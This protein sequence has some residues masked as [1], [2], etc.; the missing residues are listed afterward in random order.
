MDGNLL[1]D[2]L[3]GVGDVEEDDLVVE[4]GS[5]V[6]LPLRLGLLPGVPL[7]DACNATALSSA[8]TQTDE[9]AVQTNLIGT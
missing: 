1:E 4:L 5:G 6:L 8:F 3:A 7:R 2:E 9:A